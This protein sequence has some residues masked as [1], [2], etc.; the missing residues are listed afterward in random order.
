MAGWIPNIPGRFY[1]SSTGTQNGKNGQIAFVLIVAFSGNSF[2]TTTTRTKIKSKLISPSIA[3][4]L[5]C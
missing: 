3:G 2:T 1:P 5:K 4:N